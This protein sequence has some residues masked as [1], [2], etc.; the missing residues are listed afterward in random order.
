[1]I[2]IQKLALP[3]LLTAEL[4]GASSGLYVEVAGG[5]GFG[6]ELETKSASYVYDRGFIGSV[7]LGYQMD[8]FRLELEGRYKKDELYSYLNV[9]TT[10]DA[11]QTSQMVNVYYSGYNS[12]KI[13]SSVGVGVGVSSINLEDVT[14]LS[15][16]QKDVKSSG[17]LSYQGMFSVG[18]MITESITTSLKYTYFHTDKS[19]E[20]KSN[21]DSSFSLGLRYLF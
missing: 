5:T 13:V 8:K 10:G 6:D 7:A 1:M 4:F 19:D 11:V 2:K 21:G 17:I 20:F 12:S 3:L 16:P 9:V 18:Y 15:T 14:Q